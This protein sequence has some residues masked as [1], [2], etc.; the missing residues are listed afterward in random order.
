MKKPSVNF[1]TIKPPVIIYYLALQD[2]KEI[3]LETVKLLY[4]FNEPVPEFETRFPHKLESVLEIPKQ[5]IYGRELYPTIE[6]KAACYF[7]FIIKNHPLL[8][9]NKRV[10]IISS[11][12]FLKL[13]G[14][15]FVAP[16]DKIYDFAIKISCPTYNHEKELTEVVIFIKKY[17]K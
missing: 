13:N 12:V 3:C 6:Q 4:R 14:R 5:H 8:N 17:S 9:G 2:I 10:A 7:Y 15:T 1:P 16:W 11:Y